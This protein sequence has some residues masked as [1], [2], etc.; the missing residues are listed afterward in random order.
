MQLDATP[1]GTSSNSYLTLEAA[2]DLMGAFEQLNAWDSLDNDAKA[3]LLFQGTRK[4]DG[5]PAS[6]ESNWGPPKVEDQALVFPRATDEEGVIPRRVQL[7]L[8]EYCNYILEKDR[9]PI[10]KLQAE[11]VTSSNALGQSMSLGE[12]TS[13]LP[14]GAR[15]EL[16]TLLT[17]HYPLGATN[18]ETDGTSDTESAFG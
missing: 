6:L 13:E 14:G 12:D 1:S 18:R 9:V 3:R 11:G 4:I 17:S 5:Y 16:D 8:C 10:K 7:A 2:N 15:R